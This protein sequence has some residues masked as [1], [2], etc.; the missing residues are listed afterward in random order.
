MYGLEKSLCITFCLHL[1]PFQ[2]P[3][4]PGLMDKGSVPEGAGGI[5]IQQ[6]CSIPRTSV[7]GKGLT[8]GPLGKNKNE[9]LYR[10]LL[11]NALY[12]ADV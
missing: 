7:L 4:R 6:S 8:E 3:R 2:D 12:Q 5:D 11:P 10:G 1:I 9:E